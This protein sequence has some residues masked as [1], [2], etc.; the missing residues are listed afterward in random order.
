MSKYQDKSRFIDIR[1]FKMLF[2]NQI[3]EIYKV[4]KKSDCI[5]KEILNVHL[6]KWHNP[7]CTIGPLFYP[8]SA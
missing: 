3:I 5:T 6:A 7:L 2:S 1:K 4:P 8:D